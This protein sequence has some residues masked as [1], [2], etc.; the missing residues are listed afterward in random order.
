[1]SSPGYDHLGFL[2]DTRA[3]VDELLECRRVPEKD[4]REQIKEYEDLV[5]GDLIVHAFYVKYL[6]PIYFDVQSMERG[7]EPVP[8][9]WTQPRREPYHAACATTSGRSEHSSS[10]RSRSSTTEP[11]PRTRT[12]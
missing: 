3:E 11:D 7:G 2:Q 4:D 8:I 5:A 12:S 10:A 1:M 6:L 9:G